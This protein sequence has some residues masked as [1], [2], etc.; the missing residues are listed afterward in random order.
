[1]VPTNKMAIVTEVCSDEAAFHVAGIANNTHNCRLL[2]SSLSNSNWEHVTRIR[3]T[4]VWCAFT[5]TEMIHPFSFAQ[6]K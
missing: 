1:M 6:D 5:D 4:N 3:D 2:D